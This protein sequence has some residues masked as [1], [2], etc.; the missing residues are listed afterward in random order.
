M[1]FFIWVNNTC[2]ALVWE[3]EIWHNKICISAPKKLMEHGCGRYFLLVC[4][5][6]LLWYVASDN[7]YRCKCHHRFI[8]RTKKKATKRL[9]AHASE[10]WQQYDQTCFLWRAL[11]R[12]LSFSRREI[13]TVTSMP[14]IRSEMSNDNIH[15]NS[16]IVLVTSHSACVSRYYF[17]V[18]INC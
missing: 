6:D 10:N 18:L 4:I 12:A 11:P 13:S 14:Q 8:S 9:A 17:L 2:I 15:K 16:S 5:T 7:K 3:H 1:R